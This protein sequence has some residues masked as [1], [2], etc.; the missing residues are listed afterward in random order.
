MPLPRYIHVSRYNRYQGIALHYASLLWR[1]ISS[2]RSSLYE[3]E[4]GYEGSTVHASYS[5]IQIYV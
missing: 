1:L 2:F 4:D 5:D 3:K